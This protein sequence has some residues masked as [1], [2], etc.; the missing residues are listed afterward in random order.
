[1]ANSQWSMDNGQRNTQH[2]TRKWQVGAL[3]ALILLLALLGGC[4]STPAASSSPEIDASIAAADWNLVP[5]GDFLMGLHNHETPLDYDYEMMVTDVTNEQ[6]AAF[7]DDALADGAIKM[8]EGG[9]VGHYVGDEFGGHKHEREIKAGD[10]LLFATGES[11]ARVSDR[12]GSFATRPGYEIHPATMVTW[13]GAKAFCEYYG[14]R[15]PTETEWEKA[16]RGEDGLAF[17]WGGEIVKANA[18]FYKSGDPFE[19]NRAVGDTTP[20]G[21]YNGKINAYR[22]IDSP[23]PYGL[24]DMA[25]NVWQWTGDV[26]E[27]THLRYLKGGSFM[28]YEYNLRSWTRNSAS[29]D[30]YSI[31]VGF[32]CVR[33]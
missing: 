3:L 1:M 31:S 27:D 6:F 22:T 33:D 4:S 19:K 30:Y 10:W 17:P 11:D 5:A 23:S 28:D 2:A 26:N 24:Y 12:G 9:V 16:A 14:W 21:Y 15:L 18:N 32:R 7:L 20:V 29:P 13:F 25:G 8:G